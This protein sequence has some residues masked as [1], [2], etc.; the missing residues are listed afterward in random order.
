MPDDEWDG[1]C[2]NCLTER[3]SLLKG[4]L[5]LGLGLAMADAAPAQDKDP[6]KLRPQ[7]G[8]VLVHADG[9]KKGQPLKPADLAVDGPQVMAWAMEPA[10]QTVR[11]GSRLNKVALLRLDPQQLP[12]EAAARSAEGVLAYSAVC[13]HAGCDV[14]GWKKETQVLFCP[15]HYSEFDPKKDAKVVAGPAPRALPSLPVKAENGGIV[16]AGPFKGRVG[17]QQG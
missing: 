5:G 10:S 2:L 14:S 9:D 3:R 11:D 7:P 16:V 13:T 6:K 17:F 8:D 1:A 15:C 4:A 12:P